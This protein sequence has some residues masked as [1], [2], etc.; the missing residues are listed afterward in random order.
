MNI[1]DL[2]LA[3]LA[4]LAVEYLTDTL[5]ADESSEY[6]QLRARHPDFDQT[7]VERAAAALQLAAMT[8]PDPLPERVRIQL[9][10]QAAGYFGPRIPSQMKR[11]AKRSQRRR[12]RTGHRRTGRRSPA[13]RGTRPAIGLP[14]R[15][16]P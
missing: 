15:R 14:R 16:P 8:P 2:E 6:Q 9:A 3:R 11:N 5:S 12:S 10:T 13:S 7:E 1:T 4:E